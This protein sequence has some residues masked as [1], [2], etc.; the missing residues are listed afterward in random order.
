MTEGKED[1]EVIGLVVHD[2]SS[3]GRLSQQDWMRFQQAL[4]A[5]KFG[6]W[7]ERVGGGDQFHIQ[8]APIDVTHSP[9]GFAEGFPGLLHG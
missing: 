5:P 4:L 1:R 8:H 9:H 2:D 6:Q 3:R 7:V